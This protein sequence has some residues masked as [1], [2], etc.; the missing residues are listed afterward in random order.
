M[1]RF[2]EAEL[3]D[4]AGSGAFERGYDYYQQGQVGELEIRDGKALALVSGT[5]LYRVEIACDSDGLDGRCTCPASDGIFF[6]KH[7]VA[8]ALALRDSLVESTLATT[9]D[10][11][12]RTLHAYLDEQHAETLK[13]WLIQALQKDPLLKEKLYRQ[14]RLASNTLDA[15]ELKRSITRVT[16][17]EDIFEWGRVSAYFRRLE[18]TL[19]G[20]VEIADQLT[21]E[22]LLETALHGISRV[23]K[24]LERV[25]DSGGYR[26]T[27]RQLLR[28]LHQGALK[29]V[30]WTPQRR[31]E[32]LLELALADPWDQFEGV[33]LDY[34]D[35]LGDAGLSAFYEKVEHRFDALPRL[36]KQASF[37]DRLPYLRL[38]EYLMMRAREQ[39]DIDELIRLEQ[40][41]AA[42][43]IDFERIARLYLQ[44]GDSEQAAHWLSRADALDK[45][46]RAGRKS[47]WATLHTVNGDWEAAIEA[48][49][50]AFQRDA[51]YDDYRELMRIAKQA[52]HTADIRESVFAFLRSREQAPSWSDERRAGTLARILKDE[53]DWH[54]LKETAL[55]RIEDADSLLK[56]ARWIAKAQL[57]D[58]AP[59]FEKAADALV[60]KKSN[61]SY[62]AAVKVL[63][64]ARPAF[65][66]SDPSAFADCIA[67]LRRE[68]VR[69]RNF[70]AA[71]DE[72]FGAA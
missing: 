45:G 28:E 44:K 6:C 9:G 70:M 54:A 72:E 22:D 4:L 3:R 19:D 53:Q 61:R 8:T 50:A 47:L 5:D 40:L 7:C 27:A 69:K 67:R 30:E 43:G 71:L 31:A 37:E 16:P 58:A 14:A 51:R 55:A 34:A 42:T 23:D 36:S 18:E 10:V 32:H 68:H 48:Q 57:A 62:R 17:L 49:T 12:D 59:V 29:R 13:A 46:D 35:A 38:K 21:A 26:E 11:A 52:G 20:I 60:R 33:P 25:D 63:R 2:T 39:G 41:T 56:V 1:A 24:A 15:G 66:A 64:D 65:E